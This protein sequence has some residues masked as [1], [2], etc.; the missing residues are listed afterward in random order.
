MQM[1]NAM[2]GQEMQRLLE[3]AYADWKRSLHFEEQTAAQL[4]PPLLLSVPPV[5]TNAKRRILFCGQETAGWDW[6]SN[7][8]T[9]Y[10]RYEVDYPYRDNRTMQDFLANPDAVDALCWGYRQFDFSNAQPINRRSPFWQAFRE[11]Q[12]WP[13]AGLI[14]NNLSRC[15]YRSGSVL[16]APN[17]VQ[18]C[19]SER[20]RELL[21]RELAILQPQVCLFF[22]GPNYDNLLSEV[23][24]GCRLSEVVNDI[25]VRQL[26]RIQHSLLP[27]SSF[28]TYHP[29]YLSRGGHWHFLARL[30]ELVL[31]ES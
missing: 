8:R 24:P 23:F 20:Q 7:L 15:D 3:L 12:D 9:E 4:S 25:P 16:E 22:T 29:S 14:W 13:D 21:L 1:E 19:L 5:Y 18:T 10:P 31:I 2:N 6:T 11:V 27:A 17:E 28:R 30:R 26:A